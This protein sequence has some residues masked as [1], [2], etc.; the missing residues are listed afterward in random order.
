MPQLPVLTEAN[1][2][3]F[4]SWHAYIE[5]VYHQRISGDTVVDLNAF[6]FFY[7]G[8]GTD[9]NDPVAAVLATPCTQVCVLRSWPDRP[10]A[11]EGTLFVG[12]AGPEAGVGELGFFVHRPA[13]TKPRARTC[14]SLEVMHVRTD[15][16]G[17][18]FGISWFFHAVGS[19]V[20][21]DCHALPTQGRIL[22][23]QDRLDWQA[24][25]PG[26]GWGAEGDKAENI[27][28]R[29]EGEGASMLIFTSA[30][31]TVFGDAGLNPSTEIVVRHKDRGSSELYSTY[32]S[33]LN[34]DPAI[35]MP[36]R[37]GLEANVECKCR[38]ADHINCDDT[39][40]HA[41]G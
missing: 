19:G 6:T 28:P 11:Y 40:P 36:L 18:E 33:C 21:L 27:L 25:H 10:P 41:A 8:D 2:D 29:M 32:R 37:T 5:R 16:L 34:A 1:R 23:Y 9:P 35:R 22:V 38:I 26:Q 39:P 24:Q 15:W 3:E 30:G 4:P 20:F 17:G 13:I 14:Q 12:D 31:F 7:Y